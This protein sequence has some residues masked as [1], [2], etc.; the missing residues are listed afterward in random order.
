[1]LLDKLPAKTFHTL[2]RS[3]TWTEV[4]VVFPSKHPLRRFFD[5]LAQS[6]SR[7]APG[8]RRRD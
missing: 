2:L 5:H 4:K 6:I 8:R 3:I 1:M 7:W